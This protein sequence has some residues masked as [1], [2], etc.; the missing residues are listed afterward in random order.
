[1]R[2]DLVTAWFIYQWLQQHAPD[3]AAG[4]PLAVD[5][6]V[7]GA[8]QQLSTVMP[9]IA[10]Q[11]TGQHLLAR[12]TIALWNLSEVALLGGGTPTPLSPRPNQLR[13]YTD[14]N[15]EAAAEAAQAGYNALQANVTSVDDLKKL[16]GATTAIATGL[17]HFL[18]DPAAKMVFN[19]LADAGF[20]TIVFNHGRPTEQ[21]EGADVVE[22]YRKLGVTTYPRNVAQVEA[23]IP[24][25]WRV[26]AAQGQI[27]TLRSDPLIAPHLDGVPN[28]SDVFQVAK[29]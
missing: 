11:A 25:N 12:T 16:S 5:D 17:F 14:G 24:Q 18:P 2:T 9:D 23:V 10:V 29:T 21:G 7:K 4:W 8:A 26:I 1:M 13:Y 27:D 20:E 28:L 15:A 19:G 3:I 22:Q 6:Q